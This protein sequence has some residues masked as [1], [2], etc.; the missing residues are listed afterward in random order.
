MVIASHHKKMRPSIKWGLRVT[1]AFLVLAAAL[2]L[3]SFALDGEFSAILI[4]FLTYLPLAI[5]F[6]ALTTIAIE[7]IRFFLLAVRFLERKTGDPG[8]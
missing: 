3:I 2:G 7:V 8:W 6:G 5:T 1:C 4:V